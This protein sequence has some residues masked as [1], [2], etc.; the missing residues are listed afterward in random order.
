MK[1][2]LAIVA[3]LFT[4]VSALISQG[5]SE[6]ANPTRGNGQLALELYGKLKDREGNVFFS[7]FSISTALAMTSAGAR[8]KTL[9][10]MTATLHLPGQEQLHPALG[11][12]LKQINEP[13]RKGCQLSIA[14]ALWG[15]AGYPFQKGV[16][17]LLTD[18]YGGAWQETDFARDPDG[19]RKKI[20]AWVEKQTQDRIKDLFPEGSLRPDARLVLANAVSF[21]GTWASP[22]KEKHTEDGDF[23]ASAKDRV[24]VPLMKQTRAVEYLEADDLQIVELP[25][26]DGALSMVLL[27]P[28]KADGL[29]ALE[30]ALTADNLATWLG[31][32]RKER[33]VAVTLPRFQLSAEYD[34]KQTLI[35]LGMPLAFSPE[36][37]FGNFNGGKDPLGLSA[38]FHK[39]VIE[40]N[41]KGT[42]ASAGTGVS[43][44]ERSEPIEFKADHPFVFLVRDRRSDSLLFLGRVSNP[45]PKK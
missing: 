45:S 17:T 29:P 24:T 21:K 25:Y 36:A 28:R 34:L 31:K 2:V 15:Q 20:N 5:A 44:T 6:P 40:V 19:A 41:E 14:N 38:V 3:V 42:E 27:L 11:K 16:V 1:R 33:K 43:I 39:A 9:E 32:M 13:D 4:G 22:F 35:D 30:K 23:F 37:D 8:G 12:L 7:P 18:T 10:Q 26:L